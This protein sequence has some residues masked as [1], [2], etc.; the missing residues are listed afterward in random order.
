[1]A[2]VRLPL[3]P[4]LAHVDTPD[5]GAAAGL[6]GISYRNLTRYLSEGV[7]GPTADRFA[8]RLGVHPRAVWGEQYDAAEDWHAVWGTRLNGRVPRAL[9]DLSP[10]PEPEPGGRFCGRLPGDPGGRPHVCATDGCG[11]PR[12]RDRH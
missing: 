2:A 11:C 9:E 3:A 1:V 6:L 5:L 8:T 12:A 7:Y 10:W 4:L